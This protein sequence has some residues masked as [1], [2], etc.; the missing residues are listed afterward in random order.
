[1]VLK[2][3]FQPN[4]PA[5]HVF[6][7]FESLLDRR[8]C[9]LDAWNGARVYP[10]KDE[11][12]EG[13]AGTKA[14]DGAANVVKFDPTLQHIHIKTCSIFPVEIFKKM[15]RTQHI[16]LIELLK[17][18]QET[19]KE[20]YQEKMLVA[21]EIVR[22]IENR[23]PLY[24]YTDPAVHELYDQMVYLTKKER[25]KGLTLP[26]LN[27]KGRCLVNEALQNLDLPGLENHLRENQPMDGVTLFHAI[28]ASLRANNIQFLEAVVNA[29]VPIKPSFL[30]N[31][32]DSNP[33][34]AIIQLANLLYKRT[35]ALDLRPLCMEAVQN[36]TT[37][38]VQT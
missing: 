9:V 7:I 23:M 1:L 28:K 21:M 16:A 14:L 22:F 18:F 17:E 8:S 15:S 19:P 11:Y 6:V 35:Q 10:N 37:A 4:R 25:K 34:E 5:D 2:A 12:L 31:V 3:E 38:I 13:Y 32:Y 36:S 26:S 30:N 24:E 33:K 20:H 29:N 27:E